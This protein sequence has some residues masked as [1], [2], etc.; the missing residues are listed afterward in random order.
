MPCSL[1]RE[2]EMMMF[3]CTERCLVKLML[4]ARVP[5]MGCLT[6]P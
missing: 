5:G 6:T 1:K 4:F 2:R 3:V